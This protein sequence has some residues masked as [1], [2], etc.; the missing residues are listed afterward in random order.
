MAKNAINIWKRQKELFSGIF[1]SGSICLWVARADANR[2]TPYNYVSPKKS[3][4]YILVPPQ[5]IG[6]WPN[7]YYLLNLKIYFYDKQ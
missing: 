5:S 6:A 3:N 4:I 2:L 1:L 7:H